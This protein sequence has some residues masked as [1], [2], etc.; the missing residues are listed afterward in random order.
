VPIASY[1][2]HRLGEQGVRRE[3]ETVVLTPRPTDWSGFYA[4]GLTASSDFMA[5]S[6]RMPVQVRPV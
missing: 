6:E 5:E 3:G 2:L 4:S 1:S